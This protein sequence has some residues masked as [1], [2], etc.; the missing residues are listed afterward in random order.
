MK[1]SH[2]VTLILEAVLHSN[3]YHSPF[4]VD[5]FSP[6][7]HYEALNIVFSAFNAVE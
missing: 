2:V 4:Q 7:C 6:S 5:S 3:Y 1:I